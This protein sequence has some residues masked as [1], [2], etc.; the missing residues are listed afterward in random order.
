MEVNQ[1]SIHSCEPPWS[2]VGLRSAASF[3][4]PVPQEVSINELAGGL[5]A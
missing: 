4:L 5:L 2:R 3:G 1:K